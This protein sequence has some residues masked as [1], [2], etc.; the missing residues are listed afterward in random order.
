MTLAYTPRREQP[1][2]HAALH[3]LGQPSVISDCHFAVQLNHFIPSFLSYS[4]PLCL[5]RKCDR[6]LGQLGPY[7]RLESATLGLRQVLPQRERWLVLQ[8]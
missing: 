5:K 7:G 3:L 6:T 8:L 2:D 1:P 4:V